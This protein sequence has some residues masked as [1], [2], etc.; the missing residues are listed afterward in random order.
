MQD[1]LNAFRP[2]AALQNRQERNYG[3][4]SGEA[5]KS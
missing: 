4:G 3:T 1:R 2:G 5:G